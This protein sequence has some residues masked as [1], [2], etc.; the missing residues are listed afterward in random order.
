MPLR[1]SNEYIESAFAVTSRR[2]CKAATI[3]SR[4]SPVAA[5]D[6]L[7]PR[8]VGTVN[9]AMY[10][11]REPFFSYVLVAK[12]PISD[13]TV[14]APDGR[15]DQNRRLAFAAWGSGRVGFATS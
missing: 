6:Q 14:V 8:P 5:V 12:M 1:D 4:V 7:R 11:E 9:I 13:V 3:V 10:P 2:L 15:V